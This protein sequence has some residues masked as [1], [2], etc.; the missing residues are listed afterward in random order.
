V[1]IS[2][3]RLQ[4]AL[5]KGVRALSEQLVPWAGVNLAGAWRA[6]TGD[7][8]RFPT[9]PVVLF[10]PLKGPWRLPALHPRGLEL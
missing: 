9:C 3:Y 4:I 2:E 10:G 1:E 7:I 6:D 8:R 5:Q